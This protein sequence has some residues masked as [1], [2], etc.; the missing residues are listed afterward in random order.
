MTGAR[1]LR[2]VR[3]LVEA[4]D[5]VVIGIA[6]C[7][8]AGKTTLAGWLAEHLTAAGLPAVWV[9]MD[10]FHLADVELERLGRLAR[11]GAMDT[12][13]AHGYLALLRR[14]RAETATLVY[15]PSFDR[16]I[17]QP[18][19]GAIPV[20]PA[21]RV[22]VSEGNYLLARDEPWRQVR[23]VMTEVWYVDLDDRLRLDRLVKRHIRFGKSPDHAA[24]WV[25]EVDEP[26]AERIRATRGDADL[27]LDFDTLALSP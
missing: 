4:D 9:P 3:E 15:A 21:A 8:G 19:A 1:L 7:P 26:N 25:A 23:A 5:R 10:G 12:F 11:K 24:R 17:E 13:D 22:V 14:I 18:I 20:P 27:L 16:E 6:G 2:R